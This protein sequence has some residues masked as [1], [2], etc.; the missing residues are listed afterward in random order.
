MVD[1]EK[2]GQATP[3]MYGADAGASIAVAIFLGF[4]FA[5]RAQ[6]VRR[7]QRRRTPYYA[8]LNHSK[9]QV[10][11][12]TCLAAAVKLCCRFGLLVSLVNRQWKNWSGGPYC[13]CSVWHGVV[14][15]CRAR[16]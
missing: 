1:L 13:W 15:L 2:T 12:G 14:F 10:A 6:R 8:G 9:F 5:I 16:E 4:C 11:V 3:R 7:Y